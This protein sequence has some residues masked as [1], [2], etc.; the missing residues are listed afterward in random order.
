MQFSPYFVLSI[1]LFYFVFLFIIAWFTSRKADH[2]AF[3]N[4]NRKSPWY[5]ISIG[6]IGTSISGVTFVSVP[7]MVEHSQFAYLQMVLGFVIGYL[8]VAQ[9]LLPLYYKLNLHSI[10]GYLNTRYGNH[11]YKTGASFFLVSRTLGSAIR[12]MVVALVLQQLVFGPLNIPFWA[13]T[14]ATISLIFLYSFKGGVKTIIWTDFFQTLV[15]I[16]TI[17]LSVYYVCERM[18]LNLFS[19][20]KTISASK[21]SNIFIWDPDS[22]RFFWKQFLAGI[23]TVI[24][25]TGLDQDM[26]QKNLSCKTLKEAK[27]NIYWHGT[28]YLPINLLFLSLGALIYLFLAKTGQTLPDHPDKV[29]AF[30]AT[31]GSLPPVVGVLFVLGIVAAAY[32]SADSAMTALTTSFTLD[33]LGMDPYKPSIVKVRRWVHLGIALVFVLLII[34][35]EKIQSGSVIDV[36]YQVAGY[37]YGPLLGMYAFGMFSKRKVRDRWVPWICVLAPLLCFL[38]K[39]NAELLFGSYRFGFELLIYN[40]LLTA[41]G[42]WLSGIGLSKMPN[43]VN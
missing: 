40:G 33:I 8:L 15:L 11:A 28:A 29:F 14:I 39:S 3:F 31:N 32:S 17:V 6:M 42:L 36:V 18:D 26:M 25:M 4:G 24:T 34:G 12:L 9:V 5:I 43:R 23:F 22:P 30:A 1:F 16:A 38:A 35:F 7:G 37:T 19:A 13:A 10:Y 20:V 41:F 2:T 21:Y 27:K